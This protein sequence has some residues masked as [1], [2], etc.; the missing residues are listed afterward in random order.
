MNFRP[1]SVLPFL[2]PLLWLGYKWVL[3][4]DGVYAVD[5]H[6][7]AQ[8]CISWLDG[9]PLLTDTVYGNHFLLHN[10]FLN[11]LLAPFVYGAGS[12]GLFGLHAA[13][14]LVALFLWKK[15]LTGKGGPVWPAVSALLAGPIGYWVFC[16]LT[17]GW[18]VELLYLPLAACWASAR[19]RQSSTGLFFATLA[20]ALVKENA[21][22]LL[23]ALFLF[24]SF[25]EEDRRPLI[26]NLA[27]RSNAFIVLAFGLLFAAGLVWL[28]ALNGWGHS[29]LGMA[30]QA[31]RKHPDELAS[32]LIRSLAGNMAILAGGLLPFLALSVSPSRKKQYLVLATI[33]AF[34][35]IASN[36]VEGLAY[37][38]YSR[39]AF[40]FPPRTAFLWGF[41]APAHF[42]A[43]ARYGYAL[44][45]RFPVILTAVVQL[46]VLVVI[47][48][49]RIWPVLTGFYPRYLL[50]KEQE[51]ALEA[52]SRS[53]PPHSE[54]ICDPRILPFFHQHY[55]SALTDTLRAGRQPDLWVFSGKCTGG[56]CK[57]QQK[58]QQIQANGLTFLW[59]KKK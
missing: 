41:L 57:D 23:C 40:G 29:R 10:Y 37:Y 3:F 20:I 42:L 46:S 52:A 39:N 33:L 2:I 54:V 59:K 17:Q 14:C 4:R 15:D 56:S 27:T 45:F 28:A 5:V 36:I 47:A 21:P 34:P 51:T 12:L 6:A 7:H 44:R 16:D 58:Y 30:I 19:H 35:L 13:L 24:A 1:A 43:A 8:L 18:H 26:R 32:Y 31:V 49:P 38:P 22:I 48:E 50:S 55:V 25:E 11:P 53:L 9:R